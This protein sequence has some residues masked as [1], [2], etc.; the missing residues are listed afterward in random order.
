MPSKP[1]NG[2]E[3][4]IVD[5]AVV[6]GVVLSVALGRLL[7][8]SVEGDDPVVAPEVGVGAEVELDD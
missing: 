3:G 6:F 7:T 4:G 2:F 5:P 8:G 1:P